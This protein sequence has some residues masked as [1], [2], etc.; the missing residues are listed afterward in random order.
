MCWRLCFSHNPVAAVRYTHAPMNN[1]HTH[2]TLDTIHPHP[3]TLK[4]LSTSDVIRGDLLKANASRVLLD[5]LQ[6]GD[7]FCKAHAA[8][9]VAHL[10]TDEGSLELLAEGGDQLIPLLMELVCFVCWGVFLQMVFCAKRWFGLHGWCLYVKGGVLDG[11][12]YRSCFLAG[13]MYHRHAVGRPHAVLLRLQVR[14]GSVPC[15]RQALWALHNVAGARLAL[16]DERMLAHLHACGT[17]AALRAARIQ[18][19]DATVKQLAAV[20]LAFFDPE[21]HAMATMSVP[22][23]RSARPSSHGT[24]RAATMP[25][26]SPVARR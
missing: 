9:T 25:P 10:A 15:Q 22:T 6:H 12:L 11:V 5:L 13:C 23:P 1:A 21:M 3:Q 20:L 8:E 7:E 18:A 17:E 19:R 16:G 14:N 4:Q 26:P 24:P 2:T